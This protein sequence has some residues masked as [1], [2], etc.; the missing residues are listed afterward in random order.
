MGSRKWLVSMKS[1]NALKKLNMFTS[2]IALN[3]SNRY[4]IKTLYF[5]MNDLKILFTK[6]RV[7]GK[8][9]KEMGKFFLVSKIYC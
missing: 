5:L 6:L 2:F 3:N 4:S 1:V 8:G 7:N 9:F